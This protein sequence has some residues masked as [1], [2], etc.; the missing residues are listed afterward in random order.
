MVFDT[1]NLPPLQP[2]PYRLPTLA[3][4][5]ELVYENPTAKKGGELIP[6]AAWCY[7]P[8]LFNHMA[9]PLF[10]CPPVFA[11]INGQTI[12]CGWYKKGVDFKPIDI[13]KAIARFDQEVLTKYAELVANPLP[14][15]VALQEKG[16]EEV[17]YETNKLVLEHTFNMGDKGK[18][19]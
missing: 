7:E 13:A 17:E 14:E 12:D 9:H 10:Q 2:P 4:F 19:V 11:S 5:L 3:Y 6:V 16:A 18:E 1:T 8:M 15:L